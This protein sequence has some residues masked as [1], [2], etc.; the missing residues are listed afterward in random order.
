MVYY[1]TSSDGHTIYMGKDKFENE[2]LIKFGWPEDIW[3]HVDDL[4]S[5]HVYLRLKEGESWD[6]IDE[7]LIAE[8]CQLVKANSIEGSKKDFVKVVYTPWENLFKGKQMEVG[9]VGFKDEKQRRYVNEVAKD[10]DIL[11]AVF[12]TK[13][14]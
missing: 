5:A 4:S 7:K 8:C 9:A 3:F 10:R 14:E 13:D 6:K 12:K 2:D 1:F 11:R